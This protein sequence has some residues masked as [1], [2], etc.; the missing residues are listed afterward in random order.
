MPLSEK[1]RSCKKNL[2]TICN[3][4]TVGNPIR[5]SGEL[6]KYTLLGSALRKEIVL[7]RL[8]VQAGVADVAERS[9]V[10]MLYAD[11]EADPAGAL[12]NAYRCSVDR[13]IV[14]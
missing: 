2:N 10:V 5:G 6:K 1:Q 9:G 8:P 13:V 11:G 4:G 14:V 12:A 3:L 7:P